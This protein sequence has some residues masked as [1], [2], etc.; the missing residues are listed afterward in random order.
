MIGSDFIFPVWDWTVKAVKPGTTPS[1]LHHRFGEIQNKNCLV[2]I[3][4][5]PTRKDKTI[6]FILTNRP[7]KWMSFSEFQT[8]TLF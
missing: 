8:K 6:D 1:K 2:Q 7:N 3:V 5:E 4:E